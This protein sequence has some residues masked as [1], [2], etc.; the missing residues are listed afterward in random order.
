MNNKLISSINRVFQK[1]DSQTFDE[2]DIKLLLIDIREFLKE[3]T[4]LREVSDFV[5]HPERNKGIC[6][7]ATDSR[8]ARMKMAKIGGK[9]L[10]DEKIW[11]NNLDK[12]EGFFSDQI[13]NYIDPKKISTTDYRLFVQNSLTDIKEE[14]LIENYK[15]TKKDIQ[16]ILDNCYSKNNG[17]Y[18][19]KPLSKKSF[20]LLDDLLKF[21]R[22]TITTQGVVTQVEITRDLK[23][24]IKKLNKLSGFSLN[25]N[26]IDEV[27]EPVIVCI[28]A[29]LHDSDFIMYDNHKAKSFLS[30][31]GQNL[32]T[33][34]HP[35]KF[36]YFTLTLMIDAD[37]FIFPI[38]TTNIRYENYIE[39]TIDPETLNLQRVPWVFTK[40]I[41]GKLKLAEDSN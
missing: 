26:L 20:L 32:D 29:L 17:H 13:L 33:E 21:L 16:K 12:P 9:R 34:I 40:R 18:I 5:A 3:E 35:P 22:G 6:H 23:S 8:Y 30:I 2:Y 36:D 10:I 37:S 39:S 31:H 38:L 4:F 41:E 7:Q 14:L 19:L 15:L 24:A 1:F 28:I 25:V 11:E 27:I